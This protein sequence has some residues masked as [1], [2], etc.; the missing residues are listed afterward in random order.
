MACTYEPMD[1]EHMAVQ[2]VTWRLTGR[3]LGMRWTNPRLPR[4]STEL[5]NMSNTKIMASAGFDPMTSAKNAEHLHH[6]GYAWF[7]VCA[8][9][10]MYLRLG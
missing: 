5:A 7:L 2:A 10:K 8:C 4:G 1:I 3:R 6:S 9:S